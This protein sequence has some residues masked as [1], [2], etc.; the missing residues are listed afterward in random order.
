M[1]QHQVLSQIALPASVLEQDQDEIQNLLSLLSRPIP[2][3]CSAAAP[4]LCC[5]VQ[6]LRQQHAYHL[7]HQAL[8]QVQPSPP[9]SS[10]S[11]VMSTT[12]A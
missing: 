3:V 5:C 11:N 2:Q 4:W 6:G 12:L 8:N 9:T 10:D 7:T 1:Q